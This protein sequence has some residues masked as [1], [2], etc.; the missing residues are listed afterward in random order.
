MGAEEEEDEVTGA[1]GVDRRGQV[2][3]G[4]VDP[5][6]KRKYLEEEILKKRRALADMDVSCKDCG[7]SFVFTVAEQEFFLERDWAIPRARCK[8]CTTISQV[9]SSLCIQTSA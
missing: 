5:Q 2:I 1:L 3:T 7:T 6:R 4:P 8:A 9:S